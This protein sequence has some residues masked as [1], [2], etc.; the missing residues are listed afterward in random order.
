[1]FRHV[2]SVALAA[3]S[4]LLG[5]GL[6]R[7]AGAQAVQSVLPDPG[8]TNPKLRFGT[9][10]TVNNRPEISP[11][12]PAMPGAPSEWYIAQWKKT[13][14]LR[15]E[16]MA[17]RPQASD[18]DLGPAVY[19]FDT[20]S[21]VSHLHIFQHRH[22]NRYVYE[23]FARDGTLNPDGGTGLYMSAIAFPGATF[24]HPMTLS[25][26]AKIKDARF[27]YDTPDA[28]Q[29]GIV[30]AH[31]FA[32]FSILFRDPDTRQIVPTFMQI[33]FANSRERRTNYRGCSANRPHEE[34]VYS[35]S[36]DGDRWLPMRA[37]P[38]SLEELHYV[39]NRYL[40]DMIAKPFMCRP[41]EG[42]RYELKMP[43]SARD[44]RNWE[45][46]SI[47]VGLE[48]NN[49]DARPGAHS[50]DPQGSADLGVQISNLRV[51]R[52]TRTIVDGHRCDQ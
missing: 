4:I 20:P 10:R 35:R 1:M 12:A 42:S 51:E 47:Y 31:F 26:E 8:L 19:A 39:L 33:D 5:G 43:A 2:L 25:F 36:L 41:A 11:V 49:R 50:T 38:G 32:G 34:I 44:F 37:T 30:F 27:T 17:Q 21:D 28:Q 9:G 6:V 15:P 13:E 18:P 48:T 3:A 29:R 16:A 14:L 40:C 52:D 23:L 24:E 7:H 45:L 46:K 22:P